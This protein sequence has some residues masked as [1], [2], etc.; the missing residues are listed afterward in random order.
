MKTAALK[1]DARLFDSH[2]ALVAE[3]VA[4]R[5]GGHISGYSIHAT[6]SGLVMGVFAGGEWA[7]LAEGE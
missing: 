2:R 1:I 6:L 4:L 3:A 7:Y 5:D